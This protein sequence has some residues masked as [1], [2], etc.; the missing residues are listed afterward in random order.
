MEQNVATKSDLKEL[1][2]ELR[3]EIKELRNDLLSK[4]ESGIDLGSKINYEFQLLELRLTLKLGAIGLIG[5]AI[6]EFLAKH[7]T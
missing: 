5:L 2:I 4:R 3:S 1:R 6:V 7:R